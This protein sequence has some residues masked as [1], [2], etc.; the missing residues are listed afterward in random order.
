MKVSA[1]C[2]YYFSPKQIW[3]NSKATATLALFSY[4]SIIIPAIVALVWGG[5]ALYGRITSNNTL[6]NSKKISETTQ[7]ILKNKGI[8]S[9]LSKSTIHFKTELFKNKISDFREESL[10]KK[11]PENESNGFYNKSLLLT[12]ALDRLT[13]EKKNKDVELTQLKN[14]E[15]YILTKDKSPKYFSDKWE[16]KN[17]K[18]ETT[19]DFFDYRQ[20][21][22]TEQYLYVDYA[23]RVLG[24][25]WE[26]QGFVQEEI[27]AFEMPAFAA[28]LSGS[29]RYLTREG[30][31][32]CKHADS[33]MQ[34]SPSPMLIKGLER[35]QAIDSNMAYGRKLQSLSPKQLNEAAK[36]LENNQ[37]V[38]LLAIAAPRLNDRQTGHRIE[39]LKDIF[40]TLM[41]GLELAAQDTKDINKL[42]VCS[43][44][45]GCGAF[46]N[47]S[48][49][50]YLL[51]CLA[52]NHTGIQ[53]ILYAYS[54]KEAAEYKALWD[55]I[56]P[57]LKGK[58]IEECLQII[59]G[60]LG[61]VA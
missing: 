21:T 23:N 25:G 33:V 24:G 37:N 47:S 56:A 48:K 22:A 4:I 8:N 36:K 58:N 11:I 53:G 18:I 51:H 6:P 38:N 28:L 46:N 59:A 57:K 31:P 44:K 60:H 7:P 41:A 52:F 10:S 3:Q 42:I 39:T 54:D 29:H 15:K 13:N 30:N 19:S 55:T 20:D 27:M 14:N 43:G 45:F 9:N 32:N 16:N 17:P 2:E 61:D 5:S 12:S 26:G 1:C 50:V 40:N 34:G 35:T 49:A